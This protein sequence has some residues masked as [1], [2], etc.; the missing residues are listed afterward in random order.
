MPRRKKEI[1]VPA[2]RRLPSGRWF[3]QLRLKDGNGTVKSVSV[4]EDTEAACRAKATAIKAGY[5]EAESK[6]TA[7]KLKDV[8]DKYISSK[9]AVLSPSTIK[10]YKTIRH[11]RFKNYMEKPI[12]KINWQRMVNEE[13]KNGKNPKT[14]HNSWSL[15]SAALEF[16]TGSKPK[17]TLPQTIPNEHDFLTYEQI[18]VFLSAVKG[19][20]VEI[21]ALLGLNSLRV[22]EIKGLTWDNINIEKQEI[23]VSGSMVYNADNKLVYKATNKNKTSN[24][25]VPILFNELTDALSA[26][27]DKQ[28]YVVPLTE[29]QIYKAVNS[30][31]KENNLP[32]IGC[33]GLRHS[34]ASACFY[35]NIPTDIIQKWGGWNEISTMKRIYTHVSESHSHDEAERF[36]ASFKV[37]NANKNA[38]KS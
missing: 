26:V 28:G 11:N 9:D 37:Q 24:R 32:Q 17:I 38:N 10:G 7:P 6:K 4:T 21:A 22:S 31:C 18:K 19:K 34:F 12:D 16:E 33:H 8:L 2:P 27:T 13:T 23:T 30:V 20:P 36:R 25:V 15:V 14:V 5:I 1:S 3:I 35:Q 29:I